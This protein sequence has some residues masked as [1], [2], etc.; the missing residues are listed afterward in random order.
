MR[1]SRRISQLLMVLIGFLGTFLLFFLASAEAKDSPKDPPLK[2]RLFFTKSSY[3]LTDPKDPITASITLKNQS[4]SAVS[5]LDEFSGIGFQLHLKFL[6]PAGNEAGLITPASG[7]PRG[8]TTP[9]LPPKKMVLEKLEREWY[10]R[11]DIAK[12]REYYPL[13]RPGQYKV[14]FSLPFVQFDG[15]Q[16]EKVD[17]D[18]DGNIDRYLAPADAV[19]WR[20]VLETTATY[21][22]LR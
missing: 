4:G 21:I 15:Q 1:K 22:T 5:T 18:G 3:N 7:A 20:G 12:M 6:G 19:V 13:T 14:W 17:D 8:S 9:P 11:M 16:V 2:V 10:I